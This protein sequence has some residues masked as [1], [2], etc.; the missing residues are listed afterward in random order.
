MTVFNHNSNASAMWCDE[1]KLR[2]TCLRMLMS[3]RSLDY[4]L[5]SPMT[6]IAKLYD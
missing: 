3:R 4:L 5:G 2:T 6:M 1:P